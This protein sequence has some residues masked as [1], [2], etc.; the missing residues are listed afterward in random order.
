MSIV[1]IPRGGTGA[2]DQ[3]CLKAAAAIKPEGHEGDEG[4]EGHQGYGRRMDEGFAEQWR[5]GLE[6]GLNRKG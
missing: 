3:D 1:L 4:K 6:R 5:M 2:P